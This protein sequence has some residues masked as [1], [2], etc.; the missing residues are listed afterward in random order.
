M[1]HPG[2][3]CDKGPQKMH[4]GGDK[5]L[6]DLVEPRSSEAETSTWNQ[7]CPFCTQN[8]ERNQ[9]SSH[10]KHLL[11]QL[12]FAN[13]ALLLS[14]EAEP[15]YCQSGWWNGKGKRCKKPQ[16]HQKPQPSFPPF[17]SSGHPIP[18]GDT[19]GIGLPGGAGNI[20]VWNVLSPTPITAFEYWI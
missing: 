14:G 9:L 6:C 5:E 16:M 12:L 18:P 17:P 20:K 8:R 10:T 11:T 1:R 3:D 4:F 7:S 15:S 2:A 13:T 19:A